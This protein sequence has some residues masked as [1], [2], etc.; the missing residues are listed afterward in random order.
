M[1]V[2][3]RHGTE[4]MDGLI[5]ELQQQMLDGENVHLA[6]QEF[7]STVHD[8][9]EEY[10]NMSEEEKLIENT[11]MILLKTCHPMDDDFEY[12]KN[13]NGSM[14]VHEILLSLDV[15]G[16]GMVNSFFDEL[17]YIM[18]DQIRDIIEYDD[19]YSPSYNTECTLNEILGIE[20]KMKVQKISHSVKEEVLESI[21]EDITAACADTNSIERYNLFNAIEQHMTKLRN[22]NKEK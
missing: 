22:E 9:Q 12:I 21:L 18:G 20:R 10:N 14:K 11:R 3:T 6:V 7:I 8:L 19:A 13:I 17:A 1:F 4:Q 5:R 16:T 15:L 2:S